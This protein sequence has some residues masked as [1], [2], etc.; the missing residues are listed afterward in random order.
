MYGNAAVGGGGGAVFLY[1]AEDVVVSCDANG[2]APYGALSL[3][4]VNCGEAVDTAWASNEGLYGS[5]VATTAVSLRVMAPANS[6]AT[7]YRSND[8]LVT[9]VEVLDAFGQ[10]IS[11][12]TPRSHDQECHAPGC[13]VIGTL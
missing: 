10:R 6:T 11:G 2:T 5:V 1:E 7:N 4:A 3:P 12:E 9:T 8:Q 13:A